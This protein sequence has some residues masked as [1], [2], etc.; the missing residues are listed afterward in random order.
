MHGLLL[1]VLLVY[2]IGNCQHDK[3][4]PR[5]MKWTRECLR[6]ISKRS[7]TDS[8]R[9][10]FMT[11]DALRHV[12]CLWSDANNYKMSRSIDESFCMH[13][14]STSCISLVIDVK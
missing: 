8:Q 7:S 13:G 5:A 10:K 11:N 12:G 3:M 1:A 2:V 6:F 9:G 14:Q 4:I